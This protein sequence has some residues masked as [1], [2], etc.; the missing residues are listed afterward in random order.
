[1]TKNYFNVA[2]I[3]LT[4]FL[5]GN[6]SIHISP[7]QH[8][9]KIDGIISELEWTGTEKITDL[10]E[11]MPGENIPPQVET[12]INITYD[13][14][15]LYIGFKAKDDPSQIRV[16]QSKRD[17]IFED[18]IVGVIIDTQND[19][20]MAYQFFS[21]PLGNQADGQKIGTM[22]KTDWDAVWESSGR[23]TDDGYEVEIAIPFQSMQIPKTTEHHWRI[24]F[25]R[26]L[27][28][29]DS[30]KQLA[31]VPFDRN[32][33]C[34]LCQLGHLYGLKN[35]RYKSPIEFLPS[36]VGFYDES[37]DQ[38][39]GFGISFPLLNSS[40]E[41]TVNPDF[42]QVES[43]AAKIDLNSRTA[44]SYPE[45]RPFF[46]EGVDLFNTGSFSWKPKIRLVYTR[47]VNDPIIAAKMLGQ[48][49]KTQFGFLSA[50]DE[51]TH[52]IIPFADFGTVVEVG[53]SSS[54]IFRTK[55]SLNDGAY[56]GGILTDRRYQKGFNTLAG[57]DGLYRFSDT[58][59]FDWQLFGTKTQEPNDI[60]LTV[61]SGVNGIEFNNNS[62]TADFDGEDFTG[63]GGYFNLERFGRNW[64]TMAMYN[65]TSPGFRADNG[66]IQLNDLKQI[67]GNIWVMF[68]P[69]TQF[70]EQFSFVVAPGKVFYYNGDWR[71]NWTYVSLDGVFRGQ[72]RCELTLFQN[73]E[74]YKNEVFENNYTIMFSVNTQFSNFVSFGLNPNFGKEIIRDDE[75][76]QALNQ[77]LNGWLKIKPNNTFIIKS[78]IHQ[79][80][81]TYIDSGDEV[82]S[83]IIGRIRLEN[84]FTSDINF[85]IVSQ[86][87][88]SS[89]SIDVQP[90]LSYQ[91][92]PFTI[93]YIGSSWTFINSE[94]DAWKKDF[95]QY[96]IK[97]QYLFKLT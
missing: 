91:P 77:S 86:Y 3:L 66:Y 36:A 41:I 52:L 88:K 48:V 58:V 68:Y 32:N 64:G 75:P 60:T 30:R 34:Q 25:F 17:A 63:H 57:M 97:F 65:Y 18:D 87:W 11:V 16:H 7:A 35:I 71:E 13:S 72:T 81:S 43:D 45:T 38:N 84:Q 94:N 59:I 92:N 56:I 8:P 50:L 49:G 62:L 80:R 83:D 46:N 21:N 23:M 9:I 20:V 2:L 37:F 19:A 26:I 33:Q 79:S 42:S 78:S 10:V 67:A 28:R 1:M 76:F 5:S 90:L 89:N 73:T 29:E 14:E 54:N 47:S 69:E 6:N 15:H 4:S 22:D 74:K 40:M 53:K 31:S 93:F 51:N 27:P 55:H 24:S 96:Y 85:R 82:Y 44:L 61:D 39:F 95:E 70:V 12:Q